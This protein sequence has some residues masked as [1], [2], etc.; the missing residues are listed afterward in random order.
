MR[1]TCRKVLY[2]SRRQAKLC[3][4]HVRFTFRVYYCNECAGY[5]ITNED[6]SRGEGEY[7]S[8]RAWR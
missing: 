6:K 1:G 5:H 4:R 2:S 7:H 8:R 3:N